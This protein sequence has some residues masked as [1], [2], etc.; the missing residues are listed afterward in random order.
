MSGSRFKCW[1]AIA[2]ISLAALPGVA[3]AQARA[4][5]IPAEDLQSAL[6]AYI[7]QSGIELVYRA[8][9]VSGLNSQAVRGSFTPEEALARLL[10]G[11]S[12][13]AQRGASGAFVVVALG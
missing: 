9:D 6:N 11:T 7:S 12:L 4:I 3:F 1:I 10:Q 13:T 8:D 2:S 5:D